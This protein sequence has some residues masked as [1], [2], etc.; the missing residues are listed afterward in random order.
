MIFV[1]DYDQ[2]AIERMIVE[3][4]PLK[5]EIDSLMLLM[6]FQ[7]VGL[8]EQIKCDHTLSLIL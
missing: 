8:T 6:S 7:W 3:R 1:T 2:C 5:N 4:S